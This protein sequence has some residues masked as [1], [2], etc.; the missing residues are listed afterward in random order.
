LIEIGRKLSFPQRRSQVSLPVQEGHEPA[1][2]C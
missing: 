2:P 1:R